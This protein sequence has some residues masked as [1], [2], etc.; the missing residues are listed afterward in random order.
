MYNVI[1]IMSVCLS[2]SVEVDCTGA[3][4]NGGKPQ[5]SMSNH[6]TVHR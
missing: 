1:I 6:V 2:C 4:E 5:V 3:S